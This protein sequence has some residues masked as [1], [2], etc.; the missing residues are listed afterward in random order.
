M[1]PTR[2]PELVHSSACRPHN[3]Q[4]LKKMMTPTVRLRRAVMRVE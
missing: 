4:M 1:T 3:D 2:H